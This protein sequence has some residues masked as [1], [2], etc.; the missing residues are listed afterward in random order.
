MTYSDPKYPIVNPSPSVDDCI[1]AFRISDY[2]TAIGL[3]SASWG[4][5]YIFGKPHRLATAST[6]AAL[7]FTAA[8]MLMLQDSRGRLMG[9]VEND[10]EVKKYGA[11]SQQLA[12]GVDQVGQR[13]P[14]AVVNGG[15]VNWPKPDFQAKNM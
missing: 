12:S 7:G 4:Y 8:G 14:T 13:F 3:T 1:S 2:F 10:R 11:W 6:A 5:G 9:Y 15:N